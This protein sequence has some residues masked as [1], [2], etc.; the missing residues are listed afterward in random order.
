MASQ[1][2]RAPTSQRSVVIREPPPTPGW[3]AAAAGIC[4]GLSLVTVV[5]LWLY[6]GGGP[7]LIGGGWPAMMSIGRLTGLVA[8]NLLL[9]QVLLLARIP[10][11]ERAFGQDRLARW[12]R[13][14]GF[15][16]FHLM[17]AHIVIITLG[18]AGSIRKDV[19]AQ[20]RD[21]VLT[22]PGVLLA[23]AGTVLLILVVITSVRATRRRL[24]YESWHLLH[25]Y[26]YLGVGLALPHQLWSGTD[27]TRS[28]EAAAYWW[29]LYA[30]A[31]GA[32]LT[33]R[34]ARPLWRSLRH[35]IEVTDVV[36]EGP[37][38]TSVYMRGRRLDRLG[39]R[40]GQFFVWRFL[41]GRGWSR[42]HP[43]SVSGRPGPDELRITVKDVGDGSAR[44]ARLR[45]G[46]RVLIE[47][48]YGRLTGETYRGGPVTMFCS[49]IG[50]TPLLAL[51]WELPYRAGE[52]ILVYRAR[53][54]HDLAFR[55]E[56][57]WLATHRGVRILVLLGP[58]A[59]Q[60]SSWL[61]QEYEDIT[62]LDAMRQVAP[63][64]ARH[65]VYVCGPD[66]WTDAVRLAA[67]AAGVPASR[68]HYE[69]FP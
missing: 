38:L 53:N 1:T 41:D 8:S 31:A 66:L 18:Y 12:H 4:A 5:A 24:R 52:A 45:P 16:S 26:A 7:Q 51:L 34:I 32:V 63:D 9:I 36:A 29:T 61:P 20:F 2:A 23:V 17:L 56:L 50:I 14:T 58:R 49:G 68:I 11:L 19:L 55:A 10:P 37:D 57:G 3:W 46:T 47:G 21:L 65:H 22:Y 35:R 30:V 28:P 39:V 15:T 25:L 59:E 44:V 60:R 33:F 48:P 13:L 40:A 6:N 27:F 69:R 43:Y 54:E 64:I 67:R 42:A 62:D